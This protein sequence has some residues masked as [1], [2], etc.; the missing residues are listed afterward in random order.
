MKPRLA[1]TMTVTQF[2]NGYWY[3]GELRGFAEDIGIPSANKLRKDELERAVTLFLKT[4]EIQSP[5]KRSLSKSGVRDFEKG[6]SPNL[7]VVNYTSNKETKGFIEREARKLA[8]DLKRKSGARYRLNRWRE[9]QLTSGSKI[10][11]A[12]LV[13]QYVRLNQTRERF[14]HIPHGRYINFVADFLANEKGATRAQAIKAWKQLK[15][16]DLPKTYSDWVRSHSAK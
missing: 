15:K 11:Y 6:L 1:K 13:K 3:V 2:E 14:A 16:M 10:T 7:P 9:E 12:D 5:T 4:G 8:P